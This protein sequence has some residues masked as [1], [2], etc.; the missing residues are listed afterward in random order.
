MWHHFRMP[1]PLNAAYI[2][3]HNTSKDHSLEKAKLNEIKA[4]DFFELLDLNL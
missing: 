3:M 4:L 1:L 2:V